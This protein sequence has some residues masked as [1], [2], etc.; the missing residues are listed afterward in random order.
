MWEDYQVFGKHFLW[1]WGSQAGQ[2]GYAADFHPTFQ[3]STPGQGK[4]PKKP[5]GVP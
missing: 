4:L 3:G 2:V 5:L 1:L